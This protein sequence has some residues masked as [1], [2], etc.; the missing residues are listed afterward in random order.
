MEQTNSIEQDPPHGGSWLRQPTG[1][2]VLN[3]QTKPAGSGADKPAATQ[4]AS[5]A[6]AGAEQE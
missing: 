3:E 5:A 1:E 6:S 2:L 4:P